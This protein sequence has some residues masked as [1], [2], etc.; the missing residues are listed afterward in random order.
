MKNYIAS[1]LLILGSIVS[2]ITMAVSLDV[3]DYQFAS[4]ATSTSNFGISGASSLN[5]AMSDESVSSFVYVPSGSTQ[6]TMS[7]SLG[8]NSP[9]TNQTG[10]DLTFFFVGGGTGNAFDLTIGSTTMSYNTSTVLYTD[11]TN[12]FVYTA[13]TDVGEFALS[14]IFVDLDSYGI[15]S[16][17]DMD[18]TLGKGAYL[19][20]VGGNPATVSEVPLPAAAWLF[21]TGLGA[22][23][24][25]S[26]RR[27]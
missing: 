24:L 16:L 12:Q 13:I 11:E 10:N 7:M 18:I 2:S 25:I 6:N 8:F 15:S 4:Y 5:D 26:R 20:L 1:T 23:G 21:I 3:S 22:L 17:T 14:A 27:I 19:A 9:V